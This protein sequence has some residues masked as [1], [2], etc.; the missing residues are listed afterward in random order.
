MVQFWG[1]FCSFLYVNKLPSAATD[2]GIVLYADDSSQYPSGNMYGVI[3]EKNVKEIF[4]CL[5]LNKLTKNAFSNDSP[6]YRKS[7]QKN[8]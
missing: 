8:D 3:L 6:N 5:F 7:F 1:P 4:Q 2:F